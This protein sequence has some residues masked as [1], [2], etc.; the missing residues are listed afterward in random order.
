[1]KSLRDIFSFLVFT[2]CS[3]L[4]AQSGSFRDAHGNYAGSAT[5]N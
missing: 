3:M 5:R 4:F 1:M 2:G